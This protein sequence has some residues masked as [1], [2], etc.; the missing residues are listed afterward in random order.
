MFSDFLT[1]N[2][3]DF[4]KG[5]VM[6]V[7]GAVLG[8]VYSAIQTGTLSTINWA[9]I[10]QCAGAAGI[11]YLIKNYFSDESGKVFGRIG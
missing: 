9:T 6:A 4:A 1:L 7:L 10:V 2:Y 8:L 11:G 3:K 5:F